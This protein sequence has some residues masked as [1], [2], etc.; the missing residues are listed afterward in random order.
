MAKRLLEQ[1]VSFHRQLDIPA[2]LGKV[3]PWVGKMGNG[4]LTPVFLN[5]GVWMSY[6]LMNIIPLVRQV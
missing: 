6:S 4:A 2:W 3:G 1:S 5:K